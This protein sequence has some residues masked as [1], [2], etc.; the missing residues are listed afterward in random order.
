MNNF[1]AHFYKVTDTEIVATG[2]TESYPAID[3]Q[4]A[5]SNCLYT[6]RLHNG[7]ASASSLGGGSCPSCG[8][9]AAVEY[10]NQEDE[11]YFGPA[12]ITRATQSD[13]ERICRDLRRHPLVQ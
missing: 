1:T 10:K 4:T 3:R 7:N 11:I 5:I 12:T 13:S 6:H 9:I 2:K 8:Q